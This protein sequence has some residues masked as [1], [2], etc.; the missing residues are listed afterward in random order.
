MRDFMIAT[1][2]LL[3]G[4]TTESVA[5]IERI[6]ASGFRD[7]ECLFYLARD[8]AHLG[9]VKR[10]LDLF[11]RVVLGGFFCFPAMARDPWLDPLRKKPAFTKLLRQAGTR[12]REAVAAFAQV[13]GDVPLGSVVPT[14]THG[15]TRVS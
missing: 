15:S 13:Q 10:A 3:E 1:R 6:V 8:L 11:Q 7:P 5:A 14:R 4:D 2:T 12:H 9:E